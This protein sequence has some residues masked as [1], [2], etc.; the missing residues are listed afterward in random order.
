MEQK[1]YFQNMETSKRK[2]DVYLGVL[3]YIHRS[4]TSAALKCIPSQTDIH[5]W[6]S[7]E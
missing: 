5:G 1:S 3:G 6:I 2:E 4:Y 7:S